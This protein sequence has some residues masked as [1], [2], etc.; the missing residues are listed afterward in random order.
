M[1]CDSRLPAGK[2]LEERNR[3]IAAALRVLEA[4]LQAGTVRVSIGANG[5]MAFQ[6]W[7]AQDR[8]EVSDVCAYRALSAGNSWALRQAVQRA[9][10]MSGRK[11]NPLSLSAGV[12]S[13]DGGKTWHPGH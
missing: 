7:G 4:K 11:L 8:N 9:E 1:P 6:G 2:T 10:A 5:A 13:H 12:H 3:E